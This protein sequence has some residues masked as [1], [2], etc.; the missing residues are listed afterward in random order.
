MSPSKTR[1]LSLQVRHGLSTLP[2]RALPGLSPLGLLCLLTH[3]NSELSEDHSCPCASLLPVPPLAVRAPITA[4]S[5]SHPAFFSSSVRRTSE[6]RS[7]RTRSQRHSCA[8]SAR[9]ARTQQRNART[10]ARTRP[11]AGGTSPCCW[12]EPLCT[13]KSSDPGRCCSSESLRPTTPAALCSS[14]RTAHAPA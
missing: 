13:R 9:K 6:P 1:C 7:S 5:D 11:A 14:L 4:A 8:A 2:A 10:R 12:P 3:L